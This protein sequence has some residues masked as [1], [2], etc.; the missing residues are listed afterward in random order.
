[1]TFP[2]NAGRMWKISPNLKENKLIGQG[3]VDIGQGETP[4]M[5]IMQ[6]RY[7]CFALVF[8]S[9]HIHKIR[10]GIRNHS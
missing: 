7:P 8:H 3:L 2:Q 4:A 9:H 5:F 10:N 6:I 1:M